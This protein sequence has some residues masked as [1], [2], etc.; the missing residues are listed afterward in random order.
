MEECRA[1]AVAMYLA[2]NSEILEIFGYKT[3][4]E[5][6]DCTYWSFVVMVR[7]GVVRFFASFS[8]EVSG[9]LELTFRLRFSAEGF[10]IL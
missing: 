6:D 10:G 7:A 4:E 8:L 2:S 9:V 5:K 3:Q 1:E